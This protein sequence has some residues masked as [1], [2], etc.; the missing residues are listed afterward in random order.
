MSEKR[1]CH[2]FIKAGF[3]L[4]GLFL[5]ASL[6]ARNLAEPDSIDQENPYLKYG[7]SDPNRKNTSCS[8]ATFYEKYVKPGADKTV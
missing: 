3:L 4:G 2:K 7:S 1:N 5:T 8:Q 6:A